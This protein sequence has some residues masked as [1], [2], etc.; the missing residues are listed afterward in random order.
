MTTNPNLN[1]FSANNEQTLIENLIIESIQY[2]GMDMEYLPRELKN[3]DEL[4]GEDE[5]S[6][7]N[8][9]YSIEMY[10]RSVGGFEGDGT[11]LSK[12]GLEIRD[13]I[14]LTVAVSRFNTVFTSIRT[15]PS[16]GD[17]IYFPLS[18]AVFVIKYVKNRALFYQLGALQTFDIVCEMFEYSSEKLNTGIDF[19][20]ALEDKYSTN[21][22]DANNVVQHIDLDVR[23]ND[24][25]SDNEV[26]EERANTIID[27]TT[28]NPFTGN[29]Y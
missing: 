26:V 19:V 9:H 27:F 14:T 29:T 10:I 1:W 11:F 25:W 28:N 21:A 12:F 7:Y 22:L 8:S 17:L 5:I 15:R 20:D 13:E 23:P 4:Y 6:E 2:Y 18:K 24:Y 3:Y 16:E